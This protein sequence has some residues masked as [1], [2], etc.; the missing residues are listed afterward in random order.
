[1]CRREWTDGIPPLPLLAP[2]RS[3]PL[4]FS[5]SRLVLC[6]LL[7]NARFPEATSLCCLF[8][9]SL[10][11]SFSSPSR[12]PVRPI[13][14]PLSI[15]L[16]P[17]P[18]RFSREPG[19]G[20]AS[21]AREMPVIRRDFDYAHY[22]SFSPYETR[23]DRVLRL[24]LVPLPSAI[25]VDPRRD[26]LRLEYASYTHTHTYINAHIPTGCYQPLLPTC[27]T[28]ILLL[29]L[30]VP[31]LSLLYFFFSF[32]FLFFFPL[33]LHC[34]YHYRV[35]Y[36]CTTISILLLLRFLLNH[37]SFIVYAFLFFFFFSIIHFD[38]NDVL[39]SDACFRERLDIKYLWILR[40]VLLR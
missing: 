15:S 12:S 29:I 14:R 17:D 1:M 9:L 40:R 39:Y 26:A 18:W 37:F 19:R 11:L 27:I 16:S 6:L 25:R 4:S 22:E 7:A 35:W 13:P 33:F 31:L 28:L 24:M 21:R 38:L 3:F 20:A 36:Y 32:S 23:G 30:L 34:Y 2:P 5:V 10:S 8:S